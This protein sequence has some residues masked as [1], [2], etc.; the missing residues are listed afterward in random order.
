MIETNAELSTRSNIRRVAVLGAGTMGAQIAALVAAQ[1]IKCDLLDMSA[2]MVEDAKQRLLTMRPNVVSDTTTLELIRAGSFDEDLQRLTDADW[3]V[4]A[5]VER[6]EP[7]L[8]LWSRVAEVARPNA[9]LSTNTSGIPIAQIA[10]ALPTEMR[11]RFLG[12]HFFNPPRYLHLLEL[13]PTSE[14]DRS[15]I[16]TIRKFGENV[17]RKGVVLAHDVP[18]FITNRIGCHYFLA[19]MRAADE[20]RLTPDEADAVS[21]PLMGRSNSATYRTIDLVGVDILLD[22]CDNTRA[23]VASQD[24][25]RAYTAP[26]YLRDMRE[27]GWLGDKSGKGFYKRER[28]A[29][30]SR[31]LALNTSAMQYQDRTDRMRE[32]LSHIRAI[33]DTGERLRALVAEDSAAAE[34]AWRALSSLLA[35][36]AA[37]L[38]EVA[39]DIASIDRA[40]RWGFNW[41]FGPFE[42]WDALGV[43]RTVA[44]MKRD[45]IAVPEW[46][47]A[48]AREGGSFYRQFDGE[49]E[50]ATAAGQYAKLS[51]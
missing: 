39:A 4:E 47:A 36:S 26:Q 30:Q 18:G 10:Q 40:M 25:K 33:E 12:T 22:I 6:A 11:G 9:I 5:I 34:F 23:A 51:G 8:A 2:M 49:P 1:G 38:G 3:I 31:I 14:T 35:Y 45:G 7:K 21:G 43:E 16:T 29:G 32:T 37:M 50:Q 17:L 28:Q 19:V 48:I 13:I 15:A 42:T 46:V 24:E 20:L 44:R 41:E 27:N